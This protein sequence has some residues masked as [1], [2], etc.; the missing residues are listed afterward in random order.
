MEISVLL[1]EPL[2]DVRAD[3]L[4]LPLVRGLPAPAELDAPLGGLLAQVVGSDFQGRAEECCI[5]YTGGRV[6]ARKVLLLGLGPAEK[7]SVRSLRRAAGV[8]ARAAR[9]SGARSVAF[10]MP[11]GLELPAERA[12]PFLVEGALYG[13]YRFE[14]YKS[15]RQEGP[16]VEALSFIGGPEIL[17]GVAYGQALAEGVS[18]ARSLTWMPGNHLTATALAER[19]EELC[20]R[21]GIEIEVYDRKGC[22][23]LGLGLL[24]AVNQGSREEPRFIVMRYKGNGGQGPWL[25]LVGKG[26]TFDTGGISLKPGE[27]MWDMKDDMGGAAA[28]LGAMQSIAR[29]KPKADIL[30]V[31][32]A[33][34]NMPDGGAYKPGDV[35][36]GL[37]G[38]TV[39]VRSTDAEGRLVLADGL[40]YAVRQGC[41]RL[42]TASTLTG[43]ANIALGP[44]RYAIVANDEGWEQVVYEAGEEAGERGWRLPHDEEYDDLIKSPIA[45]MAN[46]TTGRAAGTV[47]GGLFLMKHVGE[48]P[49]VHMDIAAVIWKQSADRFQDAGATGAG[50]R[51]LVQ[52]AFKFAE[53][54][55]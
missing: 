14:S 47:A 39:E 40:A 29:L 28:V 27:N 19:A 22:E 45:D 2:T 15:E 20:R 6:A 18:L 42:I 12:A 32:C 33:T 38:K 30:A 50:V 23:Q 16:R 10:A 17:A 13:L 9:E 54:A 51:T 11:A 34:D 5:I 26:I 25:G 21:S 24:L 37:S 52:A 41:Q 7:V 48:T 44:V 1:R 8:G 55:R 35:L 46:G 3:V 36:R 53:G 4:I 49:C 31:I 43:S